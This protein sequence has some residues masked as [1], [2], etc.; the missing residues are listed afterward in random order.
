MTRPSLQNG[1]WTWNFRNYKLKDNQITPEAHLIRTT[2]ENLSPLAHLGEYSVYPNLPHVEI[3][4]L[5]EDTLTGYA[6]YNITYK[7]VTIATLYQSWMPETPEQCDETLSIWTTNKDYWGS[8]DTIRHP[9]IDGWTMNEP[10]VKTKLNYYWGRY[11]ENTYI[12]YSAQHENGIR[13][14]FLFKTT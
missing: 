12:L 14:R 13:F 4:I 5:V 10:E 9:L 8:D 2:Q 11:Y 6:E 7:G 3:P 1:E